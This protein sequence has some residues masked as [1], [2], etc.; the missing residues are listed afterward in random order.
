[1]AYTNKHTWVNGSPPY[2]SAANLNEME[3]GI[4]SAHKA[5][6]AISSML[7]GFVAYYCKDTPPEGWL[8]CDGRAVS[9]TTY[10]ALF[11]VLGTSFGAGDGVTT[12]Q[13]PDLRGEFIRGWDNGRGIDSGRTFG[14]QQDGTR[15]LL[16]Y[17]EVAHYYDN[18]ESEQN[19][20]GY[21]R[22]TSPGGNDTHPSVAV[23]PRNVALLPCIYTGVKN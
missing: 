3:D 12:F 7:V 15:F 2:L 11:Q 6:D 19:T 13:I 5:A 21:T 9:R 8:V 1:M 20:Y 4:D 18:G 10:S 14:S 17:E 16:G 23:R 22:G